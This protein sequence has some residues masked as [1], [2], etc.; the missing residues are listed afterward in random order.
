[1][2]R[3]LKTVLET[4]YNFC[5]ENGLKHPHMIIAEELLYEV[6]YNVNITIR[7]IKMMVYTHYGI[8][9]ERGDSLTRKRHIVQARQIAMDLCY[10]LSQE[11][12][13]RWAYA[14]IGFEIGGKDHATVMHA[15]KTIKDLR[16]TDRSFNM[17]YNNIELN[18][19]SKI[20]AYVTKQQNE[21]SV[22]V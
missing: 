2:N 9:E 22:S 8:T 18:V 1:M 14:V 17:V 7:D 12:K 13:L 16:E 15:I 19:R 11:Y 4:L 3:G 20:S 10:K 5:K 6:K 21:N